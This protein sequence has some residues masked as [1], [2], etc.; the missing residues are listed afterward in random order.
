MKGHHTP[1][2]IGATIVLALGM[3]LSNLAAAAV[4]L[5]PIAVNSY[6]GQPF[7]G[8]IRV[9]GLNAAN[10]SSAVVTL[11]PASEYSKRNVVRTPEQSALRFRVV[12]SGG[13]YAIAVSSSRRVSEPFINFV[14]QIKSGGQTIVREYSAFL[15]QDPAV[16]AGIVPA[17]APAVSKGKKTAKSTPQPLPLPQP[18]AVPEQTASGLGSVGAIVPGAQP[19]ALNGAPAPVPVAAPVEEPVASRAEP[20]PRKARSTPVPRHTY[21]GGSYGPVKRGETLFKIAD[22]VRPSNVSVQTMQRALFNANRRAFATGSMD[23]LMA[24]QTLII[25]RDI[26][27]AAAARA[28]SPS[29]KKRRDDSRKNNKDNVAAAKTEDTAVIEV[30]AEAEPP[31]SD[32][33]LAPLLEA[34]KNDNVVPAVMSEEQVA[35]E[36]KQAA[37]AKTE[38]STETPIS[39][40]DKP[41]AGGGMQMDDADS[42][43]T[44]IQAQSETAVQ[45][46][47][48]SVE[49]IDTAEAPKLA[50]DPKPAA[51]PEEP[52]E[53]PKAAEDTKP[54]EEAPKAAPKVP[55]SAPVKP[56]EAAGK[57]SSGLELPFGLQLWHLLAAGGTL[58]ALLLGALVLKSKRKSPKVALSEEEIDELARSMGQTEAGQSITYA[59]DSGELSNDDLSALEDAIGQTDSNTDM[60]DFFT[61][62]EFASS[63]LPELTSDENAFFGKPEDNSIEERSSIEPVSNADMQFDDLDDFFADNEAAELASIAETDDNVEEFVGLDDFFDESS[64]AESN[65]SIINESLFSSDASKKAGNLP[66]DIAELDFFSDTL[67]TLGETVDDASVQTDN[68]LQEQSEDAGSNIAFSSDDFFGEDV[69]VQA[70]ESEMSNLDNDF[71]KKAPQTVVAESHD[72]SLDFFAENTAEASANLN[73]SSSASGIDMPETSSQ[74]A[75]APSAADIQAMD[76]NLDLAAAYI[77]SGVKLE[78]ARAWLEE[79]VVRGTPEQKNLATDLLNK[80][81]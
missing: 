4:G 74:T 3:G 76:I 34:P 19:V 30:H 12:P 49:K 44:S 15:D 32:S 80:I 39:S 24:G 54:V 63:D 65:S 67:D 58:L 26:A 51:S 60:N 36:A 9:S 16:A 2:K 62:T 55:E 78:K 79:V 61:E 52:V 46:E 21:S 48:P 20:S 23:S 64:D 57:E 72:N 45:P 33:K 29:A 66:D 59:I 27:A 7:R 71:A 70:K 56:A 43:D 50:D 73:E 40:D 42:I 1:K 41:I 14:L 75:V 22:Q 18:V 6:I 11:A 25:P 17:A 53:A 37:Q 13:G 10:A 68:S 77:N 47:V 35:E 69:A 38:P 8:T 5:G 31:K 28:E 81:S